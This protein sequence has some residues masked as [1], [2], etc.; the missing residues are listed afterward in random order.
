M[1]MYVVN[2]IIRLNAPKRPIILHF[3]KE[4]SNARNNSS[5][6]T[7]HAI[8]PAKVLSKGDCP[9]CTRKFSKSINLLT[10]AYTNSKI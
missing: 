2:I 10:A 5:T 9:N 4:I 7:I 6:G 3:F 8:K 1:K